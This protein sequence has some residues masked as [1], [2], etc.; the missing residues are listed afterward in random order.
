MHEQGRNVTTQSRNPLPKKLVRACGARCV[1]QRGA[2][3]HGR[4][5]ISCPALEG[6]KGCPCGAG[7]ISNDSSTRP[8]YCEPSSF[9]EFISVSVFAAW[10]NFLPSYQPKARVRTH[11]HSPPTAVCHTGC[12]R[13]SCMAHSERR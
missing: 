12:V 3:R 7:T 6:L 11:G 13:R 2:L 4:K 1:S 8:R 9:P 5:I 10:P